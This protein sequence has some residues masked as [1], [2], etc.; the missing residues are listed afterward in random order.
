MSIQ[1]RE[2]CDR[3]VL[4]LDGQE[5]DLGTGRSCSNQADA[6]GMTR[7]LQ[8]TKGRVDKWKVMENHTGWNQPKGG[9]SN[10]EGL[11][12]RFPCPRWDRFLNLGTSEDRPSA[13]RPPANQGGKPHEEK[14]IGEK[15]RDPTKRWG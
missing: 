4:P 3:S 10:S 7:W 8:R 15:V 2:D 6:D 12:R 5:R 9:R 14:Y 1:I 13:R 11:D